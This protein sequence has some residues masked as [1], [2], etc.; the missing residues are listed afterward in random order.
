MRELVYIIDK[1]HDNMRADDYLKRE[2]GFSSRSIKKIKLDKKC[3]ERNGEHMRMV[4]RLSEGDVLKIR[5]PEEERELRL[6]ERKVPIMYEDDDVMVF[7]KPADMPCHPSLKHPN[8]TLGNVFSAICAERGTPL[9]YRP[10]NRLDKDT[11]GLVVVAK[12]AYIAAQ[13]AG[14]VDKEYTAICT[15]YFPEDFGTIDLPIGRMNESEIA[16]Y[17]TPLGQRAVTHYKVAY[18]YVYKSNNY[19]M[20]CITLDTGRTH[21][22]RVHMSNDGHALIG[23][24]LYGSDMHIMKRQALHCS[25][26]SFL[27]RASGKKIEVSSELCDDMKRA[28]EILSENCTNA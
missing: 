1:A 19:A 11:S 5:M 6:S 21:Q 8:D 13:L 4:D 2:H 28:A 17:V 3:I 16:R 20:L 12:N 26:V 7:D 25:K 9:T 14:K 27:N 23:D 22:I 18:R 24:S 10:I 15:E